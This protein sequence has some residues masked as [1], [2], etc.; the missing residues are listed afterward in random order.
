MIVTH[1]LSRADIDA[2][3]E[4]KRLRESIGQRNVTDAEIIRA[5]VGTGLRYDLET[6]RMVA[7]RLRGGS[8]VSVLQRARP[9]RRAVAAQSHRRQADRARRC[10]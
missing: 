2:I 6:M 5:A 4:I 10:R 9:L 8:H 1:Y 3:A 7:E